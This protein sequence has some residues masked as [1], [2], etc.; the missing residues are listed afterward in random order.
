MGGRNRGREG[1]KELNYDCVVETS[2]GAL[3]ESVSPPRRKLLHAAGEAVKG[4]LC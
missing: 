4:K 2:Q 3:Q 1:K